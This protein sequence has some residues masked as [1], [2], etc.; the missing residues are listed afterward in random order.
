MRLCYLDLGPIQ[1][2]A[3]NGALA[4]LKIIQSEEGR[5]LRSRI[6][7]KS[8]YI[9]SALNQIG[10]N[11]IAGDTPIIAVPIGD[12]MKTLMSGRKL[13]DEGFYL[14]SV[15]FPAVPR[16]EGLLR[17]SLTT[18]HTD[19]NIE[20]LIGAFKELHHYLNNRSHWQEK[21]HF[22]FEVAKAH[23][24]GSNYAGIQK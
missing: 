9:R 14:N 12:E 5:R 15:L 22:A 17:I 4:A 1:P 2:H 20:Q 21:F 16:N 24:Q 18:T 8:K 10:F 3:V 7:E 11:V 6:Y 13:F 19:E 23:V